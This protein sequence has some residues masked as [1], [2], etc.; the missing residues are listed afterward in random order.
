MVDVLT[1]TYEI[2]MGA[3][4]DVLS[5]SKTSVN[6]LLQKFKVKP[7]LR[8]E[9]INKYGTTSSVTKIKTTKIEEE[10]SDEDGDGSFDPYL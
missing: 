6:K 4:Y 8:K 9:F 5:F 1:K 10:K 2:P 3:I 7:A